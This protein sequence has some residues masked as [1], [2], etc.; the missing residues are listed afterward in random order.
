MARDMSALVHAALKGNFEEARRLHYKIMKA[1]ELM[2]AENNPAGIKAFQSVAGL[3]G[4]YFRLPVVPVSEGL[5]EQ[6][7]AWL[8]DY[9][10][11]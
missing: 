4:N 2:F 7:T 5:M 1:L 6:I 9:R 11:G 10:E 3:C 8:K